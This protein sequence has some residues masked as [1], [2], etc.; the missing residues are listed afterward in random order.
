MAE[1]PD[2][3]ISL[4][5][6][7]AESRV[8]RCDMNRAKKPTCLALRGFYLQPYLLHRQ[9]LNKCSSPRNLGM[10]VGERFLS[11]NSGFVIPL[12]CP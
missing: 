5:P 1:L 11:S 3:V 10:G 6:E 8:P 4:I 9:L 12:K 2:P 7:S